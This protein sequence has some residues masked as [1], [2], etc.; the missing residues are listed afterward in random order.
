MKLEILNLGGIATLR[1]TWSIQ[2]APA[3]ISTFLYLHNIV[4]ISLTSSL[5]FPYSVFFLYFGMKT[6]WHWH[7]QRVCD[8]LLLSIWTASYSLSWL[9]TPYSLYHRR[10][11]LDI[12]TVSTYTILPSIAGGLVLSIIC[13]YYMPVNS[14][15]FRT[16]D[17]QYKKTFQSKYFEKPSIS[18]VLLSSQILRYFMLQNIH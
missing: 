14:F 7:F 2:T 17:L 1:C 11:F 3:I 4:I 16:D 12:L 5:T 13:S 10:L 6:I 8:M 18:M 15:Y 9:A